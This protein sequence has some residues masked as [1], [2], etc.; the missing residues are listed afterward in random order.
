MFNKA[1]SAEGAGS[2]SLQNFKVVQVVFACLFSFDTIFPLFIGFIIV[3]V[4][5]VNLVPFEFLNFLFLRSWLHN[6]SL[7]LSFLLL[8]TEGHSSS[9][10]IKIGRAHV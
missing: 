6:A 1:H 5:V 8:K 3:N 7:Q 2:Q 4:R 10:L 9:S